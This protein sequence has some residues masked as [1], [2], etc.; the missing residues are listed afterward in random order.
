MAMVIDGGGGS[1]ARK[2]PSAEVDDTDCALET[3][4]LKASSVVKLDGGMECDDCGTTMVTEECKGDYFRMR[5]PRCGR[6]SEGM[7]ARVD[8]LSW[9]Q[10]HCTLTVR[11]K[12]AR[13]TFK[14]LGAVR[15]LFP[16]IKNEPIQQLRR[17][18]GN[19]PEWVAG[20]FLQ[21]VAERLKREAEAL[22]IELVLRAI[23]P[24]PPRP[25]TGTTTD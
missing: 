5:C 18:I 21:I 8:L 10:P 3:M 23:T 22:G 15:Q 25:S 4:H 1:G 24:S 13:A 19:A 20:E 7:V 12:G 2:I 11:W 16:E 17:R 6:V 9:R 14:E